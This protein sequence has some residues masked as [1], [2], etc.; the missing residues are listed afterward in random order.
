MLSPKIFYLISPLTYGTV[1]S[2]VLSKKHL[3]EAE[4]AH[5]WRQMVCCV[6]NCHSK[7]IIISDLRMSKFVFVDKEK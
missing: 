1:H 7:G 5:L 2:Y 3:P 4:A 6:E